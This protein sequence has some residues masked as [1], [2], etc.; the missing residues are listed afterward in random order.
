M[1]AIAV[2][3]L[4]Q[5]NVLLLNWHVERGMP[6]A[7]AET[8]QL[9][10]GR[11]G[12]ARDKV[13]VMST[14]PTRQ[15]DGTGSVA[16]AVEALKSLGFR[17]EP[18]P[19][20]G[21]AKLPPTATL[22]LPAVYVY[23]RRCGPTGRAIRR[24]GR[25]AAGHRRPGLRHAQLVDPARTGHERQGRVSSFLGLEVIQPMGRSDLAVSSD[26]KIDVD[27]EKLRGEKWA[28]YRKEGVTELVRDV[29]H[30]AKALSHRPKS[31]PPSSRPWL[32]PRPPARTGPAGSAKASWIT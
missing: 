31:P 26:R 28:E 14:A 25:H 11:W 29:Y 13:F 18:M 27:R 9:V 7:V 30:R 17:A 6:P 5:G 15:R 22:V 32:P 20:E 4:G 23:P 10:F 24:R 3:A 16:D 1:P 19:E 2:N 12:A 21:L 8:V